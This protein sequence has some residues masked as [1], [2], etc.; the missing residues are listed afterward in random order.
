MYN[1]L[2]IVGWI[3]FSLFLAFFMLFIFRLLG[4]NEMIKKYGVALYSV[5]AILLLVIGAMLWFSLL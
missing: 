5:L 4:W 3:L 2:L 1:L